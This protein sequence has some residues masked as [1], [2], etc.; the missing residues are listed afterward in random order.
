MGAVGVVRYGL[1]VDVVVAHDVGRRRKV[2]W[3][4]CWPSC[5]VL[6]VWVG[7]VAVVAVVGILI[8]V[9]VLM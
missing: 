4:L 6:T 3:E 5:V 9:I 2:A 7:V 8:V 1:V